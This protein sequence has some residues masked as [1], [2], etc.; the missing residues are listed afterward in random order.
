[1]IIRRKN[2]RTNSLPGEFEFEFLESSVIQNIDDIDDIP[3]TYVYDAHY[4][5]LNQIP[6]RA[7]ASLV[8]KF[9]KNYS[10][11]VIVSMFL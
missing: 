11:I 3:K 7:I 1:M 10:L 6:T 5:K 2:T 8:G 4:I 9:F